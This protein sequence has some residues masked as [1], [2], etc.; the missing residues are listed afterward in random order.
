M[1]VMRAGA[2]HLRTTLTH[3]PM[4]TSLARPLPWSLQETLRGQ[5]QSI[6]TNEAG[7]TPYGHLGPGSVD[8]GCGA[9]GGSC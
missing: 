9:M 5:L 7:G 4:A 8:T 2:Q 3:P 6:R 1:L